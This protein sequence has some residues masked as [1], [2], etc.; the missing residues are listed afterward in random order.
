M[1]VKSSIAL[2]LT[3]V[4]PAV[5]A[6]GN[7][8]ASVASGCSIGA[9]A[10]ATSQADLDKLAGCPVI[11]GNLTITGDLG[12]AALANVEEIDGSLT[13]KNATS[14]SNFAADKVKKITGSLSMQDLTIL[15]GASFGSLEEVDT[16][17][18]VTL[19]AISTFGSNIQSANN[20]LIS[21]TSLETV[22]GFATLK[23]VSELNINNNRYLTSF[24]SSLE[25]VA[26]SLQ[27][28][29]N[30]EAAQVAFNQLL[31]ANNITLRDV[32]SAS[33]SKLQTVNA[34]LGF[35]NNS[36]SNLTL[37]KLT[38]VGQ[39]FFL[40]SNDQLTTVKAS[41]LT[42]IGGGFVIANN[43]KLRN[44]DGFK[45]VA[46][47]GGAIIVTGNYT[48]LDL[49]ALK[50]VRGDAT[51][52]TS[53]GNFSCDPFK[54]LQSKGA[55]QGDS[56]SCKNGAKSSSISS[57]SSVVSSSTKTSSS[58]KSSAS[59]SA[60]TSAANAAASVSGV[61]SSSSAS[62]KSKGA[63]VAQVAPASSFMGAL[64]AVAV[65]LL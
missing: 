54:K 51:F 6:A 22:D 39:T 21:D 19:P 10:T 2:A 55:I 58:S 9:K 59:D 18:M 29:F 47:V 31:W 27:F 41:N 49:P 35:I 57:K 42:S 17:S 13:I 44:I 52:Q 20:I 38:K 48:E 62:K 5:L 26:S 3:A 12:S 40:T 1:Q 63:A 16:I 11:V 32:Q 25:T 43:T 61:S 4:A 36:I 64:A 28:S 8:T 24:D 15:T 37:S 56:F 30:G 65:A 53:S 45:E 50:S 60:S 46:T 14:L 7:S 34:S 23:K 33:F